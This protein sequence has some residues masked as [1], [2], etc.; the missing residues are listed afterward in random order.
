MLGE[1][2]AIFR[3]TDNFIPS[4]LE[5]ISFLFQSDHLKQANG[6]K[7]CVRPSAA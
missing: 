6:K 2:S 1:D 3:I 5:R 4:G 7:R